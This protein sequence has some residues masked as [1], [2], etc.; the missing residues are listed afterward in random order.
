MSLFQTSLSCVEGDILLFIGLLQLIYLYFMITTIIKWQ[1]ERLYIK[2]CFGSFDS[3]CPSGP[4][5]VDNPVKLFEEKVSLFGQSKPN[6]VGQ[7]MKSYKESIDE[8]QHHIAAP[9]FMKIG[10]YVALLRRRNSPI[11]VYAM[12]RIEHAFMLRTF[13][14]RRLETFPIGWRYTGNRSA[15]SLARAGFFYAGCRDTIQ[16]AYCEGSLSRLERWSGEL[17]PMD[18][19]A[20]SFNYCRP[21]R[22][23]NTNALSPEELKNLTLFGPQRDPTT[24][25]PRLSLNFGHFGISTDRPF[26]KDFA[27]F[28]RRMQSFSSKWPS[29]IAERVTTFDLCRAG[30][31]YDGKDDQVR[32]FFCSGVL[33]NWEAG[34]EPWKEHARWHPNCKFLLD[35]KGKAYVDHVHATTATHKKCVRPTLYRGNA[36]RLRQEQQDMKDVCQRLGYTPERIDR[37]FFLHFKPFKDVRSLLRYIDELEKYNPESLSDE[38]LAESLADRDIKGISTV[39]TRKPPRTR[40]VHGLQQQNNPKHQSCACRVCEQKTGMFVEARH[41]SLP[42]GHLNY[43]DNCNRE[44]EKRSQNFMYTPRCPAPKCGKLVTS[45]LKIYY[46]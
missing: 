16:C 12:P 20:R 42:C 22:K 8:L 37:A 23:R 19:H 40:E 45:T 30:L 24:N 44:E 14:Q 25:S 43:C 3:L 11:L 2:S 21:G 17:S 33:R 26:H 6:K 7:R 1:L 34:D 39:K 18:E 27:V 28:D 29:N 15:R 10:R 46:T 32:C 13:E 4:G 41:V 36:T 9:A 31:F 5:K 35:I 38:V